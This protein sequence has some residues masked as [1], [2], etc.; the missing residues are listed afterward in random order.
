MTPQTGDIVRSPGGKRWRVLDVRR[1]V[2]TCEDVE[3]FVVSHFATDDLRVDEP[4][5]GGPR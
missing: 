4:H 5:P 2:A 3:T 1:D